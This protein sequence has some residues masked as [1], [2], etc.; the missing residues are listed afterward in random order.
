MTAVATAGSSPTTP[1]LGPA[2]T[3]W[4]KFVNLLVRWRVRITA[5]VFVALIAEDVVEG[6]KPHDLTNIHDMKTVVGCGLVMAGLA[7][8]S[9]AAGML[10]KDAQLTTSGP[11]GIIRNPLYVGSF[12]LMIGFCTLVGDAENIWFVL[13]PLL[14]LY[15]IRVLREERTLSRIF[16]D[17]WHSYVRSVPRFFPRRLPRFSFADWNLSQWLGNREYRAVSAVFVGLIAL[18][19]WRLY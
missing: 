16:G 14:A 17:Q 3:P 13:G 18:E 11:Y 15:V 7:L 10:Q 9:W 4:E 12:L 2:K 8:R 6:I 19:A 1:K 5:I